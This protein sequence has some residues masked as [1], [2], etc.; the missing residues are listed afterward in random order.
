MPVYP[1]KSQSAGR[2]RR[3]RS[4]EHIDRRQAFLGWR[5]FRRRQDR[6]SEWPWRIGNVAAI[7]RLEIVKTPDE[8]L[9]LIDEGARVCDVDNQA[10]RQRQ[11]SGTRSG[12]MLGKEEEKEKGKNA[13]FSSHPACHEP[14]RLWRLML[15]F[16][17][18]STVLSFDSCPTP[19]SMIGR[20]PKLA[21]QL[22]ILATLPC[23][24]SWTARSLL[25]V[26]T[27]YS[28][29]SPGLDFPRDW[30]WS[31]SE[32]SEGTFARFRKIPTLQV[33]SRTR[34]GAVTVGNQ[35]FSEGIAVSQNGTKLLGGW[36]ELGFVS[37]VLETV[38][39]QRSSAQSRLRSTTL[40][41]LD[42]LK[43]S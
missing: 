30:Y 23:P 21:S 24:S 39:S 36:E 12:E 20:T 22:Q 31:T 38:L 10:H 18:E 26:A 17:S 29:V 42:P 5:R 11:E 13:W 16:G 9:K 28:K 15:K 25:Q 3:M 34:E 7:D 8:R 4:N 37:E 41:E 32:L 2:T 33:G 43:T 14:D 6:L 19:T 1:K 40:S 35:L 27:D